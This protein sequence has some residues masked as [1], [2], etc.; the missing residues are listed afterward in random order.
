LITA[1]NYLVHFQ[2]KQFTNRK[3]NQE[4][5]AFNVG[6]AE[7]IKV[8]SL[9]RAI[10]HFRKSGVGGG[11]NYAPSQKVGVHPPHPPPPY[12]PPPP[13]R[14]TPSVALLISVS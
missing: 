13:Q 1:T 2:A 14:L 7:A 12:T 11:R 9:S 3:I 5:A 8:R 10:I 6:V 4:T